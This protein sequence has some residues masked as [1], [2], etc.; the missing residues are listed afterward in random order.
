MGNTWHRLRTRIQLLCFLIFLALPFV[1]VVRFDIPNQRFYFFG[2]E[3]WVNEF[4]IIFFALMF[5]MFV[6]VLM[7]VFLGRVFCGYLCPQM[8]FSEAASTIQKRLKRYPRAVFY[9]AIAGG[10][11][12][13]AVIFICYFVEPG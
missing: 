9:A 13:L 2:Y 12:L 1:N 10:S 4:G 3:L 11:I 7:S 6:V 5:L 8:I